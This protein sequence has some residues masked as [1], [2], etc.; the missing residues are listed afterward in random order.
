MAMAT[1]NGGNLRVECPH[2]G[3]EKVRPLAY[4]SQ[5]GTMRFFFEWPQGD[6]TNATEMLAYENGSVVCFG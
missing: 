3:E 2:S 5:I 4:L 1:A 6:T